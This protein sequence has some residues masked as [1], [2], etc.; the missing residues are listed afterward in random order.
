ML[1][2]S[3]V[4][5]KR[6]PTEA[7]TAVASCSATGMHVSSLRRHESIS[8]QMWDVRW[9]DHTTP[10]S[11]KGERCCTQ[12]ASAQS[13]P[14]LL[15]IHGDWSMKKK[16]SRHRNPVVLT[17]DEQ[18][19]RSGPV[20]LIFWRDRITWIRAFR[21]FLLLVRIRLAHAFPG[22]LAK[23]HT[24]DDGWPDVLTQ[25]NFSKRV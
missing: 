20:I 12:V 4:S 11:Q 5:G 24:G 13:A 21:I 25:G 22:S 15:F 9:H 14:E 6:Y 10:C 17:V 19:P 16:W 2:A 7:D 8:A 18:E 23:I 1:Q 3:C